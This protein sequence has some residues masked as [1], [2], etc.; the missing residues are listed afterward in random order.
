LSR[1]PVSI[2]VT[3][4]ASATTSTRTRSVINRTMATTR[5]ASVSHIPRVIALVRSFLSKQNCPVRYSSYRHDSELR[6]ELGHIIVGGM[7]PSLFQHP[8]PDEQLFKLGCPEDNRPQ[9]QTQRKL[10]QS[11]RVGV[12]QIV[13]EG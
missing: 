13:E 6:C 7:S 1:M 8:A 5:I 12:E 4:T 2:R 3:T 10:S 11:E 9:N